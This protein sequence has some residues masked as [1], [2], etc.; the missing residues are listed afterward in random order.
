M[1][2]QDLHERGNPGK[3]THCTGDPLPE[4]GAVPLAVIDSPTHPRLDWN[5]SLKTNFNGMSHFR[6]FPTLL[7]L[8][9]YRE[10][11]VSPIYGPTLLS[12]AKDPMSF[13]INYFAALGK[14]PEWRKVDP[15]RLARPPEKDGI[16]TGPK[17]NGTA[18]Q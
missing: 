14:E 4:E 6:I 17:G 7:T 3:G 11:D 16:P 18:P 10:N 13:T 2:A 8:M 5:A 1:V 15:A 12:P 9:G